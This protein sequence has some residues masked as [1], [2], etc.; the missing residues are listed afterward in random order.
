MREPL[1][2]FAPSSFHCGIGYSK[3]EAGSDLGLEVSLT[4]FKPGLGLPEPCY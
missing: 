3:A 2:C 4:L 1:L